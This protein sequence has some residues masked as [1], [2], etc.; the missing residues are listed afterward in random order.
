MLERVT[1][2]ADKT[3][4]IELNYRDELAA[5]VQLLRGTGEVG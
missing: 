1:V 5:C 3:V 2:R 4:G